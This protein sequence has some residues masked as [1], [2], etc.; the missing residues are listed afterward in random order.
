M[1]Q[2]Q[3]TQIS[4]SANH[5]KSNRAVGCVGGAP[6]SAALKMPRPG[7]ENKCVVAFFV[8]ALLAAPAHSGHGKQRP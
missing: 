7:V 2:V 3:Q 5:A 4:D 1:V 6:P 8:G